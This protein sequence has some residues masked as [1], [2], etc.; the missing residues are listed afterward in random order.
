[1]TSYDVF[2]RFYDR[3]MSDINYGER[4]EFIISLLGRYGLKPGIVLDLACGT[5]RLSRALAQRGCDVIAADRSQGMLS[6]GAQS[7]GSSNGRV[8]FLRQDMRS[9]DLY[10]TVSGAVCHL[11][12]I[13][14]LMSP[15]SV[16]KT[17][18]RVS[19]FT[20]PGGAF[21]FDLNS[22]YKFEN[23]FAGNCFIYDYGD[24]FCSW[25]NSYS[26]NTKICRFDLT[27]FE[28]T[29]AG[30]RR[31]DEH[32]GERAY[33]TEQIEN[34]LGASG[35]ELCEVFDGY[36]ALPPREES[37]RLLYIARKK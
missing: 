28:D 2:S 8:M 21:I 9:L 19:L 16:L 30:Y 34:M 14:H 20:E 3:L 11:D 27:F 37:Q 26:E 25:Q 5:G 23:I 32:F 18:G 12:G 36:S 10:G 31:S 1:M 4:A 6:A 7:N 17:F 29:G 33:T 22:P 13:N 35:M 15:A 24:I